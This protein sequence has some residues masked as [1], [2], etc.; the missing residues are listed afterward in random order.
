MFL[1]VI[2][3]LCRWFT[4]IIV[5]FTVMVDVGNYCS[6]ISLL[7]CYIT[8]M[9]AM[10]VIHS[11]EDSLLNCH[12]RYVRSCDCLGSHLRRG[13]EW[14]IIPLD[15]FHQARV[16]DDVCLWDGTKCSNVS[17]GRRMRMMFH[18]LYVVLIHLLAITVPTGLSLS[19]TLYSVALN[20]LFSSYRAR[21]GLHKDLSQDA[22]VNHSRF[23][24]CMNPLL[25]CIHHTLKP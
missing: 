15:V 21:L 24:A 16:R 12:G 20:T 22:W 25:A 4:H 5:L 14:R 18:T 2:W 17:F 19:I 8:V 11:Y 9:V 7:F 23:D 6:F 1:Q 10:T 13:A 3:S